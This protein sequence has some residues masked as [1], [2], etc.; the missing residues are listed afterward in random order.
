MN[1]IPWN[2][3][4][5]VSNPNKVEAVNNMLEQWEC[6]FTLL[7]RGSELG[8]SAMFIIRSIRTFM[9]E[10]ID[11]SRRFIGLSYARLVLTRWWTGGDYWMTNAKQCRLRRMII[12]T[13]AS[14]VAGV[15][16]WHRRAMSMADVWDCNG[17][18][19]LRCAD[20]DDGGKSSWEVVADFSHG[21]RETMNNLN[22]VTRL[23]KMEDIIGENTHNAA[24]H[25]KPHDYVDYLCYL[26]S[27]ITHLTV[28]GDI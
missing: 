13:L 28:S 8:A 17:F 9:N 21:D 25:Q 2:G 27:V 20:T 14:A 19:F 12:S 26:L 22:Q 23:D 6:C 4:I 24:D 1:T 16:L 3:A 18:R 10:Q 7:N 15:R 11:G 5:T